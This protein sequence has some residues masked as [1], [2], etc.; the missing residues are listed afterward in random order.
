VIQAQLLSIE[1][2]EYFR[3]PAAAFW[4]FAYPFL[5]MALLMFAFGNST[6]TVG[7]NT[8]IS[9]GAFLLCGML[10]VNTLS[11]S[12]F[13]FAI[14]L[15]EARQRGALRMFQVFPIGRF[16]YVSALVVSRIVINMLFNA[17]FLVVGSALF[18]IELGLTASTWLDFLLLLLACTATFVAL[19]FLLVSVCRRAATATAVANL[20]FFPMIFLSDLFVPSTVLPQFLQSIASNSPVGIA[21]GAFRDVILN[22]APLGTQVV[23]LA[24]L[25]VMFTVGLGVSAFTLRWRST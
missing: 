20:L 17:A 22:H 25:F 16:S 13:G 1:L 18:G 3:S 15:I 19:G 23:P 14:P 12:L 24:I 7:P 5:I 6:A 11:T 9:Y 4:T 21:G 2:K 8:Q 10:T